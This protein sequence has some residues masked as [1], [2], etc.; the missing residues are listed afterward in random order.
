MRLS[1]GIR[2]VPAYT[3][4]ILSGANS[5]TKASANRSVDNEPKTSELS[6]SQHHIW[7]WDSDKSA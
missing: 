2:S 5:R 1:P 3:P 6:E 4:L 7:C